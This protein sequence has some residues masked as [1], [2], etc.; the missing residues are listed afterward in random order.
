MSDIPLKHLAII[1]DGNRRWAKARGLEVFLGHQKAAD[2]VFEPLVDRAAERG[3]EYITFWVFSTEN[4]QRS[5]VEVE[6]LLLLFRKVFDSQVK[7]LHEKNVRVMTI[8][9]TSK[10]DSDIQERIREGIELTKNNTGITAIF[11]LNYGGQDELLR[12]INKLLRELPEN[13]PVTKEELEKYLDT[14]QIPNPDL[15]VRTSGE[16]RLS[17]FLLWQSEYAELTFPQF[18]FPEFTPEKLDEILDEYASRS[19]RFGK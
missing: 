7:R 4:W 12:A 18:N 16:Q 6:Y 14:A 17:G 8:G 11:A 19:R 10:F 13:T 15:I 1:C 9:D 2:E 3:V 5:K